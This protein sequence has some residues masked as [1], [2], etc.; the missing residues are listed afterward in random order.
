[1]LYVDLVDSSKPT[2]SLECQIR[3]LN[4]LNKMIHDTINPPT[5]FDSFDKFSPYYCSSTG[6]GAVFCFTN[7]TDL[8]EFS[9]VL[10]SRLFRYNRGKSVDSTRY[11]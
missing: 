8:F 11:I 7:P 4:D 1:M 2:I 5:F 9:V 3:K 10:H 6:D